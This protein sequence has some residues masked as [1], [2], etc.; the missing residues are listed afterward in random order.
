MLKL[1]LNLTLK[2]ARKKYYI[3]GTKQQLQKLQLMGFSIVDYNLSAYDCE[4]PGAGGN[5]TFIT[6]RYNFY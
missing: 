2:S 1:K 4:C 3:V 5:D 6:Q